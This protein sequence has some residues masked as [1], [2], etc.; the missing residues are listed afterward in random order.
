MSPRKCWQ[1]HWRHRVQ[2]NEEMSTCRTRH[3]GAV[4]ITQDNRTITDGFNG[5][6]SSTVHC[7]DG[8]CARCNAEDHQSGEA[9]EICVCTHA[10]ANIISFCAREGV[11][12]DQA[13]L[14]VSVNP[15]V[16]CFKLLYSAGIRDIVYGNVY[17][18][19]LS[20]IEDLIKDNDLEVELTQYTCEC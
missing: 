7:D 20:I 19:S 6:L 18:R 10:E 4:L 8:G 15:C 1:C 12:T 11:S 5:T 16:E 13:I 17:V 3:V 9:L 2:L 14:Y